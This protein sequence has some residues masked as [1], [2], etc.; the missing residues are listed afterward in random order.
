M[1]PFPHAGQIPPPQSRAVSLPFFTPSMQVGT[2]QTPVVQ[3]PLAQSPG[4]MHA[5]PSAHP[6][7]V[8]PQSMPV[9][10][11]FFTP[12]VQLGDW[13]VPPEHTPLAQSPGS[14]QPPPT[15][16]GGQL[17]PQSSPVSL[18]FLTP[19]VQRGAAQTPCWQTPSLQSAGVEHAR[20]SPHGGQ[21]PPPQSMAVSPPSLTPSVQVGGTHMCIW[22][23]LPP[24]QSGVP[25]QATQLP[26]KHFVPPFWKQDAPSAALAVPGVPAL[27]VPFKQV[28]VGVATFESSATVTILPAPSHWLFWQEPTAGCC[29]V[30][31]PM[32]TVPDTHAP[33]EQVSVEHSFLGAGQSLSA[34]HPLPVLCVPE[35]EL[36][37][38][39]AVDALPPVPVEP[40]WPQ[41]STSNASNWGLTSAIRRQRRILTDSRDS[42]GHVNS[43]PVSE[44]VK[45]HRDTSIRSATSHSVAEGSR[46]AALRDAP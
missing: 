24:A 42:T 13:Q 15:A 36:A 7:Q 28:F 38:V 37:L 46:N 17:P 6:G 41:P 20:P 1:L 5:P 22:Q 2:W 8:P 43:E 31:D 11:P 30:G 16:H 32:L 9:S 3:T 18:P 23:T 21:V 4:I 44:N 27:Q 14:K 10:L 34:M 19:S 35:V 39:V 33:P 25:R 12:S 29:F 40:A 45:K 26:A